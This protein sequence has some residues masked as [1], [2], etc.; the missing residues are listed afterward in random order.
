M[1]CTLNSNVM[2]LRHSK[3][4]IKVGLVVP[5]LLRIILLTTVLGTQTLAA[6]FEKSAATD[7]GTDLPAPVHEL[8]TSEFPEWRPRK[9]SDLES[10]D[11][12]L[13]LKSHPRDC[14]GIAT[15]HYSSADQLSYAVLLVPKSTST[16]GY[17]L[18]VVSKN[19]TQGTYSWKMLDSSKRQA[20]SGNVVSTVKPGKYSDFERGKSVTIK[21]DGIDLEWLE[22]AAILY[23]WS[24]GRYLKLQISD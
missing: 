23:Y 24:R 9:L 12:K 22:Q 5:P 3:S 19:T 13:W 11:Q 14:P 10:Y 16:N 17:Q 1:G 20:D 15:G 8:L 6:I 7:C 4:L 18:I 2:H 21:S